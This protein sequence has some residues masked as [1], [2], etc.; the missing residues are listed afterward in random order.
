MFKRLQERY[1]NAGLLNPHDKYIDRLKR[2]LVAN[3]DN[4]FEPL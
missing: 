3:I 2:E 1:C 4:S